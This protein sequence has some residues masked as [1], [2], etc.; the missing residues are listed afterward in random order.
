MEAKKNN[1][2]ADIH[3][4]RAGIEFMRLY[5]LLEEAGLDPETVKAI[6]AILEERAL[7]GKSRLV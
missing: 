1:R 7:D 4:D 5:G 6:K 2:D 3:A